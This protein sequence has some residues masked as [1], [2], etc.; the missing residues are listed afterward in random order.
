MAAST[1]EDGDLVYVLQQQ[2]DHYL[3]EIETQKQRIDRLERDL[4]KI[5]KMEDSKKAKDLSEKSK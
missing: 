2:G 1:V 5:E 3:V 4:E